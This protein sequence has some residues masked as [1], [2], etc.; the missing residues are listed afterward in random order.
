M[1]NSSVRPEPQ[2]PS[3]AMGHNVRRTLNRLSPSCNYMTLLLTQTTGRDC[4]QAWTKA[5]INGCN[6]RR[7]TNG[8]GDVVWMF[9][10]REW[11]CIRLLV[12]S[13]SDCSNPVSEV[14]DAGF[15]V[16]TLCFMGLYTHLQENRIRMAKEATSGSREMY[17]WASRRIGKKSFL[18]LSE[19]SWPWKCMT[20]LRELAVL[21]GRRR[22]SE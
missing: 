8:C 11:L 12:N 18:T 16:G 14:V 20:K 19:R 1:P 9:S 15:H 5:T 3:Y 10:L 2:H 6:G 7:L 21:V 17:W 4:R 22:K 13:I